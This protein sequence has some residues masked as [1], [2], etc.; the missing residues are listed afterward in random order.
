MANLRV[1]ISTSLHD[2]AYGLVLS[3]RHRI[4]GLQQMIEAPTVSVCTD[5]RSAEHLTLNLNP[6][7]ASSSVDLPS[8]C[9]TDRC[10]Q[11]NALENMH[12]GPSQ[13]K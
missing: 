10:Q 5:A 4:A 1:P 2:R 12:R 7:K 9:K 6:R 13:L 11:G 3:R 8:D